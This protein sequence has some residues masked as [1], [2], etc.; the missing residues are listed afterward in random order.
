MHISFS[1]CL[2]HVLPPHL[3]QTLYQELQ[4]YLLSDQVADQDVSKGASGFLSRVALNA[5]VLSLPVPQMRLPTG[6][7]SV[8]PFIPDSKKQLKTDSSLI[9]LSTHCN[10]SLNAWSVELT[11]QANYCTSIAGLIH[12]GVTGGHSKDIQTVHRHPWLPVLMTIAHDQRLL[13]RV[14]NELIIWNADLAGPLDQKSQIR[15][16]S[17][18]ATL[19]PKSFQHATWV[20]PIALA[21]PLTKALSRCPSFGLFV[22]NIGNE[23]C[24]FQSSLYPIIPPNSTQ[25]NYYESCPLY[26]GSAKDIT[27]FSH[28]GSNGMTFINIIEENLDDYEDIVALHAFRMD[29]TVLQHSQDV[30]TDLS[31]ELL[32]V[33]LENR[34][35]ES[36]INIGSSSSMNTTTMY[37]TY[38]HVWRVRLGK[39]EVVPKIQR[40]ES[41]DPWYKVT[42]QPTLICSAKVSKIYSQ[43][44][45]I[46]NTNCHVVHS[47][48]SCDI[49]SSLQLQLPSMTSPYLFNTVCSDGQIFC[50]QFQVKVESVSPVGGVLADSA[51]TN[52]ELSVYDVFGSSGL[53]HSSPI[54]SLNCAKDEVLHGLPLTSYVPCALSSA[55]PGRLAMAHL[56]NKPLP[57]TTSSNPLEQHAMVSMWECE[58]SGGL[59][60]VCESVLPL[61]GLGGVSSGTKPTNE[62]LVHMDWLPMENGAYL[63]ATCFNSVISIFGMALPVED[64]Q[65]VASQSHDIF[66]RRFSKSVSMP[67][68]T[69]H[70][71][72]SAWVNL[73]QFP[74]NR[75]FTRLPGTL[76]LAYTGTNSIMIGMGC[77]I[78]VYS[79]WVTKERLNAFSQHKAASKPDIKNRI[80]LQK[81]SRLASRLAHKDFVN[82]LD[83]AHS[84]NSPLPQYHP[85]ILMDLLNSGKLDAVKLILTNLL[86]YLLL[87]QQRKT[88]KTELRPFDESNI[89]EDQMGGVTETDSRTRLLSMVDGGLARSKKALLKAEVENIP[90]VSLSQLKIFTHPLLDSVLVKESDTVATEDKEEDEDEYDTLFTQNTKSYDIEFTLDEEQESDTLSFDKLSLEDTVFDAD[91]ADRLT[92]ILYYTRLPDMDDVEQ[93]RLLAIAQTVAR[94]K[95]SFSDTS[96]YSTR[97]GNDL[98]DLDSTF[99]AGYAASGFVPG[100][101][102][103]GEA[104]DD[105]GL[106]YLLALQNY[107]A[108][109]VSLPKDVIAEDLPTSDMIWAFHSDAEME[110]LSNIPCVQED[111]LEWV[112]LKNAGIGWWV[113][114]SDTLRKLIE[115]VCCKILS[116]DPLYLLYYVHVVS[117]SNVYEE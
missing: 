53:L 36:D 10:G 44:L 116:V 65:Y 34:H 11:V 81:H 85:K 13:S 100:G 37:R 9:L 76:W 38:M 109:S 40:S 4:Q 87:Y 35:F 73:L 96:T 43:P 101:L 86:K 54:K 20:P 51:H 18:V 83:Y 22:T 75:T 46:L 29:S 92:S 69:S 82:L 74:C 31:D 45:P 17:R 114:S 104:M 62:N 6:K 33:L 77:E 52:V 1:S 60:W 23:L 8:A 98:V 63:L 84:K 67:V 19:E 2:P 97:T 94:T 72:S 26:T 102:G 64:Q 78:H 7:R 66:S 50:W 99:G 107:I 91:M 58:S 27:V 70:K 28:S 16:L 12:T 105:C 42:S 47:N 106:R 103:G 41:L 79:C 24:L 88:Y 110:L 32:I 57:N 111:R 113:R 93:V 59:Q 71:A 3:A 55:Y 112:E 95:T 56:L 25:N 80:H 21:S 108:L 14:E 68:L 39:K 61:H 115:K 48:A 15:E 49:A 30:V 90:P 89:D 5:S 117:Q